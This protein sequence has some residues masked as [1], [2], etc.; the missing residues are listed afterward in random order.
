MFRD[1]RGDGT[2]LYDIPSPYDLY[3]VGGTLSLTQSINQSIPRECSTVSVTDFPAASALSTESA[4][5]L[6][7]MQ[8]LGCTACSITI[9]EP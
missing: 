5:H 2:I 4:F 9:C 6:V 8:R 1:A 7:H 3:C